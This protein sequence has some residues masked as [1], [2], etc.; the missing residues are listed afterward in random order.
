MKLSIDNNIISVSF[1]RK[2]GKVKK[3]WL[4]KNSSN[5]LTAFLVGVSVLAFIIYYR[6]G[7]TLS[8]NDA[9]SHLNV[10]R[11]V[12]DSLQPGFAQIGSVWLPL[13]H[14]LELP[15]VWNYTLWQTGLAGSIISML[16]YIVGGVYLI[17][18]AKLLKFDF[19]AIL[20]TVIVYA[21]NPNLLFM[22]TA[23]MTES[24]LIFLA[25]ATTYYV[26]KWVKDNLIVDLLAAGFFTLLSTL[27][28]YDGWF[29]LIF[30]A[31][32]IGITAYKKRGYK[33]TEGNLIFYLTLAG[34]GA[35]L[36]FV[37]NLIIFG[38]PFYFALGPYSAKAQQDLLESEGRLFSKG[39]PVYSTFLYLLTVKYNLG[40]WIFLLSL[41]GL[42]YFYRSK[43]Y[44]IYIKYAVSLLGVPIFFN[45]LSLIAGHSVIHLPT[46]SPYTWFNDRY[47]IMVLPLSAVVIG[48]LA[49]KRK[50]AAFLL[51]FIL[52]FQNSVMYLNNDVI[53]VEDGIKGA[54]G[55]YLDEAGNWLKNNASDGLILVAASSNDSLLFISGFP[56]KRF[57]TEGA[58]RYWDT[59]LVNPTMYADWVVMHKGD[60]VEQHLNNNDNFLNNYKL[61][62]RDSFSYI[63]K[64]SMKSKRLTVDELPM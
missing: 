14:I 27:T 41:V 7:L 19:F 48:F 25:I 31:V 22:Q 16:S 23:P 12:V 10:A 13:Y 60:L 6:L 2:S 50:I 3:T 36:W 47:G 34:F 33:F 49:N 58:R 39:N 63:Y 53:T 32:V 35:L 4:A 62:Y 21:L 54:S 51:I 28:R 11:R 43:N 56:L 38:D 20:V 5:L 44:S 59:S 37:W 26:V 1:Q 64:K 24:L 8:Y 45:V 52:L 18:L 42:Y 46:I 29:L 57:I 61:V 17:K 30:V 9:R 40:V 55:N 15:F